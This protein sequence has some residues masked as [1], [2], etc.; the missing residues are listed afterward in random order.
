MPE[1]ANQV[2]PPPLSITPASSQSQVAQLDAT[3]D[4]LPQCPACGR[5]FYRRRG[6]DLHIRTHLPYWIF[7]PFLGCPWRGDR[8][9]TLSMH[10][11]VGH[12]NFGEVPKLEDCKIYNP[13]PLVQSVVSGELSIEGMRAIA[14]QQVKMRANVVDKAVIWEDDWGRRLRTRH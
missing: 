8:P 11:T 12:T 9:H 5:S 14:L 4:A 6:R 1:D 10:W 13:E 7:C 3:T 2:H